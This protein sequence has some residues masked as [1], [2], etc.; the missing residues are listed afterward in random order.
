MI[1]ENMAWKKVICFT[2]LKILETDFRGQKGPYWTGMTELL[3]GHS[4]W[5]ILIRLRAKRWLHKKALI[6]DIFTNGVH[7]ILIRSTYQKSGHK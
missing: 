4:C 7:N 6:G 3:M 5:C 2:N 1:Y